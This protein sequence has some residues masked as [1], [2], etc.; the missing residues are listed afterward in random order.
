MAVLSHDIIFVGARKN[1]GGWSRTPGRS[2]AHTGGKPASALRKVICRSKA[3]YSRN[4]IHVFRVEG[5]SGALVEAGINIQR[6]VLIYIACDF[7]FLRRRGT[8]F[9]QSG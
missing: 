4:T 2:V 7:T 6:L 9:C 8:C 5:R 3:K 1:G